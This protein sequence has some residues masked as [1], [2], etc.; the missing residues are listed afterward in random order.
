MTAGLGRVKMG[1]MNAAPAEPEP[2]RRRRGRRR[3]GAD[4]REALLTA[5]RTEFAER[6]FDGATVRRIAERAGVDPAMVN[7]WFGGKE[8]LFIATLDLPI[9]PAA[10]RS[11]VLASAPGEAGE[12]VVRTF[13]TL[14][15]GDRTGGA[16]GG[17][18]AAVLRSVAAHEP[19]ARMLREFVT[20]AILRPV[21]ERVAPDR[22]AERGSLVASQ[23]IGLGMIR[24]V[25]RLEPLASASREQL[26]ATIAP[27]VQHYLT[28]DLDRAEEIPDDAERLRH[29]A[30]HPPESLPG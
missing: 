8:Q 25:V 10:V 1:T 27:T 20:R 3:G 19:A 7:H 24:Y 16:A 6:G 9:D 2:P 23:L 22:H 29:A 26:V 30:D 4:T 17:A 21:V 15:D 14:W 5:A 12:R 11:R 28:G 18:M 13:L